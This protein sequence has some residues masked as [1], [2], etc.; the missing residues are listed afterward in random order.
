MLLL[1][2]ATIRPRCFQSRIHAEQEV[3][4]V[5]LV[6]PLLLEDYLVVVEDLD[7]EVAE[8]AGFV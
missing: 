5:D 4:D 6:P 1:A 8:R 3:R 2:I 7:F